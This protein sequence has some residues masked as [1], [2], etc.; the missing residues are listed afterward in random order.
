MIFNAEIIVVNSESGK[1]EF[2]ASGMDLQLKDPR[3][4][5]KAGKFDKMYFYEHWMDDE[6]LANI[7]QSQMPK[8][9]TD[10]C[11]LN[12]GQD[13]GKHYFGYLNVDFKNQTYSLPDDQSD[14]KDI[15][16]A[17]GELLFSPERESK[18]L[19]VMKPT[20]PD[21]IKLSSL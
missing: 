10:N 8:E 14:K 5:I 9:L 17:L 18:R 4:F 16:V 15:L 2:L 12:F 3:E 7:R 13:F 6:Y 20:S 1:R 21:D 11:L 19:A